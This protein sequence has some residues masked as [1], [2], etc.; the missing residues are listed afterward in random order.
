MNNP[1]EAPAGLA[2]I[3]SQAAPE[4]AAFQDILKFGSGQSVKSGNNIHTGPGRP[5]TGR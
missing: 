3:Q 2:S 1:P 4:R 5:V